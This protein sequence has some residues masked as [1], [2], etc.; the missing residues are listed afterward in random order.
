MSNMYWSTFNMAVSVDQTQAFHIFKWS[1][2]I[3][4]NFCQLLPNLALHT[5]TPQSCLQH[6]K[7]QGPL[8]LIIKGLKSLFSLIQYSATVHLNPVL[9]RWTLGPAWQVNVSLIASMISVAFRWCRHCAAP[10]PLTVLKVATPKH[11]QGVEFATH[12]IYDLT[13]W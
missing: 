11:T 5:N 6:L 2:Y 9:T 13:F 12:I 3:P 8:K 4:D 7:E 1:V 10:P